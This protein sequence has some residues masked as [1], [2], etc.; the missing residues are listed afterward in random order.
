MKKQEIETARKQATQAK[1]RFSN[2][3]TY[4]VTVCVLF[5]LVGVLFIMD[6]YNY[7]TSL[8]HLA[9]ML[10]YL[11]VAFVAIILA[12]AAKDEADAENT[13]IARCDWYLERMQ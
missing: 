11:A 10:V 1:E 9:T 13:I 6:S 12:F 2:Y 3:A 4:C 7:P 5:V 8:Y